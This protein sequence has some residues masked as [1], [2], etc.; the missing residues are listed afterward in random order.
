[1]SLTIVTSREGGLDVRS[2]RNIASGPT[3]GDG[4]EDSSDPPGPGDVHLGDGTEVRQNPNNVEGQGI[5]TEPGNLRENVNHPSRGN[6]A[7][8]DLLGW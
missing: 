1:V 8:V 3:V 6:K 7:S 2:Q 5:E 4:D